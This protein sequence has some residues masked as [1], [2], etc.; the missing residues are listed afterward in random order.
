M[1]LVSPEN[2]VLFGRGQGRYEEGC[3]WL[4]SLCLQWPLQG[5]M[6]WQPTKSLRYLSK[7]VPPASGTR[8]ATETLCKRT[9]R[10]LSLPLQHSRD[11]AGSWATSRQCCN[12]RFAQPNPAAAFAGV[13]RI[14][15]TDRNALTPSLP[16]ELK[17]VYDGWN[18]PIEPGI[19]CAH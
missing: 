7:D 2:A 17:G 5:R 13:R 15:D 12:R 19:V 11:E 3:C 1:A 14:S 8:L 16:A 4:Q 18:L 6:R 10:S 9:S